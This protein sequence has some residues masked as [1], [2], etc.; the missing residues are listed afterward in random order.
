MVNCCQGK[1]LGRLYTNQ[2]FYALYELSYLGIDASFTKNTNLASTIPIASR[3]I[4][5]ASKRGGQVLAHYIKGF[6]RS[7]A[8]IAA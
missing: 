7:A 1:K 3:F 8:N 5:D 4:E 2:E 6:S